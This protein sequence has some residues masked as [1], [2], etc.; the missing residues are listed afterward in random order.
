MAIVTG[1][2]ILQRMMELFRA[3]KSD[4]THPNSLDNLRPCRGET[5][6]KFWSSV[7]WRLTFSMSQDLQSFARLCTPYIDFS[8]VAATNNTLAIKAPPHLHSGLIA[9][10]HRKVTHM[11]ACVSETI[12][13]Y[14]ILKVP[15]GKSIG[16]W[17]PIT[18]PTMMP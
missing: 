8:L 15:N 18:V 9:N 3:I 16:G 11:F 12:H 6:Q 1:G 13:I 14:A 7:P 4:R 17:R 2:G 10:L 5:V